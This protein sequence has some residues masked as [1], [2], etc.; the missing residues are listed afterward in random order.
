[1]YISKIS[2]SRKQELGSRKRNS[3]QQWDLLGPKVTFARQAHAL[4]QAAQI[5]GE[6]STLLREVSGGEDNLFKTKGKKWKA[7]GNYEKQKV[8]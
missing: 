2:K 4:Q 6:R 8:A 5:G 3:R 1:M 7:I